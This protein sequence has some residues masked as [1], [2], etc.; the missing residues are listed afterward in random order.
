MSLGKDSETYV[1]LCRSL[2]LPAAFM[3]VVERIYFPLAR[4]IWERKTKTPFVVSINGAQ[5][6]GKSTLTR[7]VSAILQNEYA[8]EVVSFSID[9]FYHT[10][11]QREQLA[12]RIH[13]LFITRGVPG[14]HDL[15]L[16]ESVINALLHGRVCQI[17][18]FD[19]ALDERMPISQWRSQAQ[20][21]DVILFEGWCNDSPTQTE[22]QLL[23]PINDLEARED[24][25]GTWRRYVNQK[26]QEY[27]ERVFCH[28][29]LRVFLKAP[30]FD[31]IFRWRKLQEDKL[32][33]QHLNTKQTR[34][35]NDVELRRF[36][37]HYERITRHTL[38]TYAARADIV[39]PIDEGHDIAAIET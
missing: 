21:A 31:H 20:A 35:M 19:K 2:H 29:A 39:L 8:A 32:R 22:S 10:R 16:L 7:F 33:T 26:L 6:T 30:D 25:Q 34:I 37:Q 17:P 27:H 36:M 15:D 14:T 18:L 3:D 1:D 28:S 24:V 13:P 4:L 12:Q 23:E 38:A 11:Q 5:G 9:D